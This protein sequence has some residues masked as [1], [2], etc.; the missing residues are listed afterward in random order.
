MNRCAPGMLLGKRYPGLYRKLIFVCCIFRSRILMRMRRQQL[1]SSQQKTQEKSLSKM[2][3]PKESPTPKQMSRRST[4]TTSRPTTTA[5]TSSVKP[6]TF[7]F[8][9]GSNSSKLTSTKPKK[10]GHG[11]QKKIAYSKMRM[12]SSRSTVGIKK[13]LIKPS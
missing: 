6:P 10:N 13:S 12:T 4:S 11:R 2:E 1:L 5:S 7:H 9:C 3:S 8:V